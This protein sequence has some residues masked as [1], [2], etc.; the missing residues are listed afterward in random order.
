MTSVKNIPLLIQWHEGM[1][2]APQHFQQAALRQ[3]AL[4]QYSAGLIAPHYWGVLR[5]E[6]DRPLLVA[7]KFRVLELEAVMP[8]GAAVLHEAKSGRDLEIDLAPYKDQLSA[9]PVAIQLAIPARKDDLSKGDLARYESIDGEPIAD[10][11]TG[12]GALRIP[13]LDLRVSLLVTDEPPAKYVTLPLARVQYRDE[14][15]GMVEFS[16]P[17]P[18]VAGGSI[19]HRLCKEIAE[20]VREKAVSLAERTGASSGGVVTP[21]VSGIRHSIHCLVAALPQFEAVLGSGSS[22]PYTLYLSLCDLVG[23]LASLGRGLIPPALDAYNHRDP[24]KTFRSAADFVTQMIREG[25]PESH[26]GHPLQLT[27]RVFSIFLEEAWCDRPLVLEM[28]PR[29]GVYVRDLMS[30]GEQ[31]L[32]ASKSNIQSMREK[33]ILGAAR[34]R[35][36]SEEELFPAPGSVLFSLKADPQSID[37]NEVLEILNTEAALEESSPAEIVLYVRNPP[38]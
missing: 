20:R 6:I 17:A 22:H 23:H 10:Q 28:R 13:R 14:A 33:R 36:D 38:R 2:L 37:R 18:F 31:C 19:I 25:I 30:W 7:G 3:E 35:I 32:I 11:N 9:N 21:Q 27:D 34:E 12:D 16:P 1:L 29:P 4:L 8:D 26:T 5:I 24:L 15:F